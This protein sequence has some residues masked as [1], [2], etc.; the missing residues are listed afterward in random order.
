[1]ATGATIP[2]VRC[3]VEAP[4]A[5]A[6]PA[7]NATMVI[8]RTTMRYLIELT[9]GDEAQPSQI[10]R[11]SLELGEH[12]FGGPGPPAVGRAVQAVV[13]MIVDQGL[14]RLADGLL[15]RMKLLRQV[16]AG[17]PIAEHLDH[18]MKM[19]FG[20]LQA[21]DDIGMS[22]VNVILCHGPKHIPL[23]GIRQGQDRNS[24]ENPAPSQF[25]ATS[26]TGKA[27]CT[28]RSQVP[29]KSASPS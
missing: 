15:D 18:L 19:A 24:A 7:A 10:S 4:R 2:T 6:A 26:R 8:G 5:T 1:M 17:T 29:A 14:L 25:L 28:R 21:L 13:N 12:V 23:G 27:R 11:D 20:P 16:E 3:S 9:M 22:F